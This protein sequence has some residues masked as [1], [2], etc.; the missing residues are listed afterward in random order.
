[1]H[2]TSILFSVNKRFQQ[3]NVNVNINKNYCSTDLVRYLLWS[4]VCLQL[5]TRLFVSPD[6]VVG[7]HEPLASVV[8]PDVYA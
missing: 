8:L 5:I 1:M 2:F 6:F 3:N 4:N 7:V